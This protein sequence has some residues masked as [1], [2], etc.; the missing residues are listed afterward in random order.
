MLVSKLMFKKSQ[1]P[2]KHSDIVSDLMTKKTST[3][4][5]VERFS[6]PLRIW[7]QQSLASMP[8]PSGLWEAFGEGRKKKAGQMFFLP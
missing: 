1:T 4:L 2:R 7:M 6:K 3:K 5:E 8:N